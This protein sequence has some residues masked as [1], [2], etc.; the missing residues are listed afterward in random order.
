MSVSMNS[1][2]RQRLQ[3]ND[4]GQAVQVAG[5]RLE[6]HGTKIVAVICVLLLI[7]AAVTWWSRQSSSAAVAAWTLLESAKSEDDFGLIWE[8]YKGTPAGRWARLRESEMYL[9]TGMS[10]L[11]SDRE[12]A[13]SVLKKAIQ[14]FEELAATNP[15]SAIRERALWGLAMAQES[16]SD[17]DTSKAL[18]TYQRLLND[19]P[20]TF[21]KASAEQRI[22]AL[23]LGGAKEF[24]AWFSKQNPKPTD[25]RPKD[26]TLQ[27]DFDSMFPPAKSEFNLDPDSQKPDSAKT[28]GTEKSETQTPDA[29]ATETKAPAAETE[30]PAKPEDSKPDAPKPDDSK[31]DDAPPANPDKKP[32]TESDAETKPE[33]DSDQ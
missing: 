13:V 16:T 8:K 18:D 28:D 26:G 9:Q 25:A 4:L 31:P 6:E 20:E 1:E 12:L 23:K 33:P 11:F 15:E 22:A 19:V 7:A 29:P 2:E 17:G 5:H 32:T 14:G 30:P 27:D 3:T 10:Q 21:Y 24:Y